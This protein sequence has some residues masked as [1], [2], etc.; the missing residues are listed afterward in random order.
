MGK[1]K[2]EK[3][4]KKMTP[5]EV[6]RKK[7]RIKKIFFTIVIIIALMVIAMI[8]NEFII[9]DNNQTYNLVINNNNITSNLKNEVLIENDIIYL[10][11]DDIAN[12]FDKY[13]YLDEDTNQVITTY[14]KKAAA[15]GFEKNI[16]N[17]NGSEQKIYA[18][19][20]KKDNKIYLPISEMKDVYN[21]EIENIEKTKVITMDSLDREQKKAIVS[22]DAAVKS[23]TEFIAKTVDRVSKGDRV[24]IISSKDR[25]F[26]N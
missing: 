2:R 22:S 13:I 9:L 18:H 5:E 17:I 12:F 15:I 6:S 14:E 4:T 11:K 1:G 10:S 25:K 8:A 20:I 16:V 7:K 26:K 3:V 19:A 24:I 23:S 21:V